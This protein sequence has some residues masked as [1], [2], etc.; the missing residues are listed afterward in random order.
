MRGGKR[1]INRIAI[2]A[3]CLTMG[4]IERASSNI[5]NALCKKKLDIHF[6]AILKHEKFFILDENIHFYEPS[7]FNR[8]RLSIIKTIHWLRENLLKIQPDAILVYSQFYS[9]IALLALRGTGFR[10]FISERSSPLLRWPFKQRVF[11]KLVFTFYKPSGVLAQTSIAAQYQKRYYGKNIP[12]KVIPNAVGYIQKYP[13]IKRKKTILAV[14]RFNDPLKGFDRLIEVFALLK[15]QNDWKLVFA[16]GDES[17][18]SLKKQAEQLGVLDNIVFLGKVKN[19]D[20]IYAEAGIFVIPSRS[21]GFPNALCEAMA[22]GLPCVRFDFVAGPRDIIPP[23]KDG[24]I[25]KN[26]D[27]NAM[28]EKI[29]FLIDNPDERNRLGNAAMEIVDR[30]NL[31]RVST[32]HYNFLNN[33][34]S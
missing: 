11:N 16:G 18:E 23:N 12:V 29:R 5:A 27:I 34:N 20:K 10:T 26:G 4:G 31:S 25:V 9:A 21:E 1:K 2:I 33:A 17:G 30:L 15:D 28:V 14:G 13:E 6:L 8:N 32:E 22:A 3:P 7:N 24:I 19:M